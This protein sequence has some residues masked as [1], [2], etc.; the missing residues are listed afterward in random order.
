M[1]IYSSISSQ[2]TNLKVIRVSITQDVTNQ[3]SK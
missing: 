2:I 3:Q 1:V